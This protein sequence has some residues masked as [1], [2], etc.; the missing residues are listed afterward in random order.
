MALRNYIFVYAIQNN[1]PLAVAST[2]THDLD[3]LLEDED[4]DSDAAITLNLI[5]QEE[6]YLEKAEEAY[7]ARTARSTGGRYPHSRSRFPRSLRPRLSGL[8]GHLQ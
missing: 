8:E 6:Q 4:I 3:G 1:L 7:C 5:L 2:I